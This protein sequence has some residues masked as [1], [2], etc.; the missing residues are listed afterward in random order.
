MDA[1]GIDQLLQDAVRDRALPGVVAVA[2]DREGQLYEGAFGCLSVDGGEP[3][4]ADTMFRL[5]SMT[6]AITS[7]AALQLIE[8]GEL[9]L[10]QPVAEVVD[11]F[12][13][14]EVLDGYDGDRPRLRKPAR[15]ATVVQLLT[16]TSG[17]SYWFSN[18]DLLR[19]HELTGVPHPL[20]CR[21]AMFAA[22]LVDDPG[23]RWEYGMSADWLGRV[24]EE[25]SGSDLA[26]YCDE[27]LFAPLGMTDTT[28]YPTEAQEDRMMAPH[29]RTPDGGLALST[30][31]LP[32]EPEFASGGGGAVGTAGDYLRFMRA[33][34]RGGELD[35]ER[36][37]RAETVELAFSDHLGALE[38]PGLMRSA[39][40]ELTNDVPALPIAQ[41]FGLGFHLV[42]E[43]LP[44]M[45]RAGT[46]DWA[47]LLNCYYWIDRA[48]GV[49][50]ALLTQVLPFFDA[51][52][53]ERAAGFEAT[54][55][56]ALGAPASV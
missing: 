15:A 21:R 23:A 34:L 49:A 44:G 47:G 43:D 12:G 19:Y 6:K 54:L 38:L 16:H 56:A 24:I 20:S 31:E 52:I 2:G 42:L 10:E 26:G 48:A 35:G 7:V 18:P 8:R 45:R 17:L 46:G 1:G 30:V 50:G 25:V 51:R 22:P 41:G 27:H 3:V 33:L 40:P 13:E 9:E 5:A 36:V 37:L 28:F 4:R 32:T 14:L 55:Y 29:A 11:A 39:V 53:I